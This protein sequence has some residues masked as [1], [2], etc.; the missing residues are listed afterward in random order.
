MAGKKKEN[1]ERM[2]NERKETAA[3][4]TAQY[5]KNPWL[6]EGTRKT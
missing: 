2:E 6:T 1:S 3:T 5:K 4:K